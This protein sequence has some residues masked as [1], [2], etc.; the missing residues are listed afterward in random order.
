MIAS[1]PIPRELQITNR[2][3]I[4]DIVTESSDADEW[5]QTEAPQFG[6]LFPFSFELRRYTLSIRPTFNID[7]VI[8]YLSSYIKA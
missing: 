4:L 3:G 6:V 1:R 8:E 2:G 5:I 7:E